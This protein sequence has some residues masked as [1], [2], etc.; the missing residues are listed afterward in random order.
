MNHTSQRAAAGLV[1]GM[2][3]ASCPALVHA[4]SLGSLHGDS[5][6]VATTPSPQKV[7]GLLNWIF[8]TKPAGYIVSSPTPDG[9]VAL[10]FNDID[11]T[12]KATVTD[13]AKSFGVPVTFKQTDL[14]PAAIS[15]ATDQF[16]TLA[17]RWAEK[18]I[19]S[20]G[21]YTV[22]KDG[23]IVLDMMVT[24][25]VDGDVLNAFAAEVGKTVTAPHMVT[26][27]LLAGDDITLTPS[28]SALGSLGS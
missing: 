26:T 16:N 18:G 19:E 11:D 20:Q 25:S 9:G 15:T 23:K 22:V 28:P 6:G 7:D 27:N 1:A 10:W 17:A 24:P 5:V 14:S 12:T 2:L 8:E 4:R 3:L 13:K 21:V